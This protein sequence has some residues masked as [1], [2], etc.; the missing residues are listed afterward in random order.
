MSTGV[1]IS[2]L[3]IMFW[4]KRIIRYCCTEQFHICVRSRSDRIALHNM[5]AGTGFISVTR[6]LVQLSEK[7]QSDIM[8][9]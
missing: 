9:I 8:A 1:A 3:T 5:E 2:Q 7:E 4:R 6:Y